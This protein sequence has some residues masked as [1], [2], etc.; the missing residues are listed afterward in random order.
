MDVL[1]RVVSFN[2][3][4]KYIKSSWVFFECKYPPI[5]V[6]VEDVLSQLGSFVSGSGA[7]VDDFEVFELGLFD[8]MHEEERRDG[9]AETLN[10]CNIG[11]E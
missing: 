9:T 1:L 2:G 3:S 8:T 5:K 10:D 7:C 6:R 4:I 11:F